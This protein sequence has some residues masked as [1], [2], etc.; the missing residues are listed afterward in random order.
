[1]AAVASPAV[2]VRLSVGGVNAAA[3]SASA[4]RVDFPVS[5]RDSP[6]VSSPACTRRARPLDK[7]HS[8][9]L[10]RRFHVVR[11]RAAGDNDETSNLNS[12]SA[13]SESADPAAAPSASRSIKADVPLA[14]PV[15]ADETAQQLQAVKQQQ[16]Q[17]QSGEASQQQQQLSLEDVNPV[18]LGR[19]S[20]QF[21]DDVW[22]RLIQL[23]Q[24]ARPAPVDAEDY[25]EL[26]RGGLDADFGVPSAQFTTVLVAGAT[27]RVGKVLVRKLLLRGY[28]VKAL[29]RSADA[30]TLEQLPR[31][32]QVAVADLAD[33]VALQKAVEGCN[34]VVF[35]ASARS[36]MAADLQRVDHM[37]VVNLSKAFLDYNHHLAQR[38]A[39]RSSKSKALVL[40]LSKERFQEGWELGEGRTIK[41]DIDI[42]Y[43]A[44]MDAE[45]SITE[46]GR[47]VFSGYV[48]TRGGYVEA[49]RRIKLPEGL[50]FGRFEGLVF[51]FVSDGKPY[52]LV[53]RVA[54]L[55]VCLHSSQL[56]HL[57]PLSFS[58][59]LSFEGLVFRFVSDGK[60]YSLVLRVAKD[61]TRVE[62][63]GEDGESVVEE[64]EEVE[65]EEYEYVAVVK[66]R[67]GQNTI[68]VPF[69]AFRASSPS[70]PPLDPTLISSLALRYE[71]RRAKPSV[72]APLPPG[73]AASKAGAEGDNAAAPA[74]PNSFKLALQYV[75]AFPGGE[76]T[77]FVLVSCSGAGVPEERRET[78][79]KAKMAAETHLRNSGLGY[80]IVRPGPL[81]EE[82]GGR[83][84]LVFDQ[85]NRINQGISCAD[86]AD[87]CVK[88]LHDP[89]ARNKSFDICYEYTDNA[90]LYELVAH[91]PDRANN[92]LTPA[93]AQL[94]KNT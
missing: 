1:M 87:V 73:R 55:P 49:K 64:E 77:D 4:Q 29:V 80:T 27:G 93:L 56:L 12:S 84:A 57:S 94:E 43:G 52:S 20:R 63:V 89:T 11:T 6:R 86:V 28:T 32:C 82:P 14:D 48:F 65:E 85:G 61:G 17:E 67:K 74:D 9:S 41:D 70:D 2:P 10:S 92:Y 13:S 40:R 18:D 21:L 30:E 19:R 66:T 81:L 24:I 62:R 8:L 58:H 72:G 59:T 83:K 31:A 5:F 54:A 68:R 71:Q 16:Q 75:K 15:A 69:S 50:S 78:V 3:L 39:G 7:R 23:G 34:K 33:E 79:V 90:G 46:D 35:C 47:G 44:G 22:R 25:T 88:A 91:L 42:R 53:L 37:G 45:F 36:A 38:R 51:R 26:V 60:P 76:E